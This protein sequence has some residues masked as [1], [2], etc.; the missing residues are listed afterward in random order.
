MPKHLVFLIGEDW[1]FASH[2]LSR[3][4]AAREAGWRVTVLTRV[5]PASALL[6]EEGFG[7]I[8]VD[9]VRARINPFS[10]FLLFADI[11]RH[12]RSLQPDVVHHVALKAI[13]LGTLAAG[14]A[15]VKSVVNAPVGQG[16]V[17]ASNSLKAR[18]LRPFVRLALQTAI[19]A[20]GAFAIFENSEDRMTAVA[21]GAIPSERA[22]LIPGAGVDL[23][24]F[25]PHSPKAGVIK[26]VLG[27]RMLLDKGVREYIEAGKILHERGNLADLVLAGTPDPENPGSL[28]DSV[29]RGASPVRW[30]GRVDD[31]AA[32]LHSAHIA[33][34]PSY[35]EGLPLFL[36][37]AMASGLPVVATDVTGCRDAVVRDQ[38][39][40]LFPPRDPAAL[41]DA[42]AKLILDS[43]MRASLGAAGRARAEALYG[44]SVICSATLAVYER[45]IGEGEK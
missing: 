38:T 25:R 35:R 28:P 1:F 31:M 36:L 6:R 44:Q 9:F 12:Y 15:G 24:R 26:V 4:R 3:A 43:S 30:I 39:G 42:L 33:C 19:G 13:V 20:R 34:L 5:G 16:F 17:F 45:A 8:G 2:F 11:V 37:E 40:L 21:S 32:L 18:L 7:V 27:A 23:E 22:I 10:E 41:A 29:L 14:I